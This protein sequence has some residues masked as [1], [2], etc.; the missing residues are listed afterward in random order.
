MKVGA[1]YDS[2]DNFFDPKSGVYVE[3][4][5]ELGSAFG[6]GLGDFQR[7]TL[8]LKAFIPW[9]RWVLATALDAGWMQA[10]G[11]LEAVPLQERFYT[12]GPTSVRGFAYQHVGPLD[13]LG[14][15]L[16]GRMKIAWN[17]I[18]IRRPVWK[19]LGFALFCDIANVW[20]S[21]S[22]VRIDDFRISPGA[23]LRLTTPIGVARV[24]CGWN[25]S[26]RSGEK[27]FRWML[28]MGQSF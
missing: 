20:N 4:Q 26:P 25:M 5:H 15:P 7:L 19:M 11:G 28:N 16:G 17:L 18:E 22:D 3:G 21:P 27:S 10:T 6:Q 24:D 13:S 2:R 8:R 1:T 14:T 23:G 9:G 12:G